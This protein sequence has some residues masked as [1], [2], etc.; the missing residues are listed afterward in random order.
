MIT[1]NSKYKTKAWILMVQFDDYDLEHFFGIVTDE[2]QAKEWADRSYNHY[3]HATY[4]L[5][6]GIPLDERME[7]ECCGEGV[8]DKT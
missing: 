3:T 7:C 8:Y 1:L 6:M 2:D 4:I 5:P